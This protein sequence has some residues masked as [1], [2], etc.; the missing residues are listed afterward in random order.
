M[1][2]PPPSQKPREIQLDAEKPSDREV[3]F[4]HGAIVMPNGQRYRVRVITEKQGIELKS[5]SDELTQLVVKLLNKLQ[6]SDQL[7]AKP[8]SQIRISNEGIHYAETNPGPEQVARQPKSLQQLGLEIEA[9]FSQ[10]INKAASDSEKKELKPDE[11]SEE[12]SLLIN[13][14][15]DNRSKDAAQSTET[16]NPE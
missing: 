4:E 6:A 5:S 13:K 14:R 15:R 16:S 10:I 12:E 8:L 7:P 9:L 3:T 1:S 2:V 11:A